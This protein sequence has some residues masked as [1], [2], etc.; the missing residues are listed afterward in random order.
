VVV[1]HYDRNRTIWRRP[2]ISSAAMLLVL[3]LSGVVAAELW[4]PV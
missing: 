2:A 4:L 3:A 1:V